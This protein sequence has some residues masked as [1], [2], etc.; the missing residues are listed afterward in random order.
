[1]ETRIITISN[2]KGGTGKTTTA[3]N[4]GSSLALS[5]KKVLLIDFDPQANLSAD[6]DVN[7]EEGEP[8]V[9]DLIMGKANEDIILPTK[10][11]GLHVIPSSI[12]LSS[13]E[14]EL[15][16]E[17]GREM[18]LKTAI[19]R[20]IKN[21][22]FNYIVI[23]TPP[24]L[25]IL[26]INA[27]SV[28]T[29]VIIPVQ[30]QAFAISGIARLIDI[31]N[32]VQSKINPDLLDWMVLPTMVDFRHKEDRLMLEKIQDLYQSNT[33]KTC[34]KVNSKLIVASRKGLAINLYDKNSTG[35]QEYESLAQELLSREMELAIGAVA[36]SIK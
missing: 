24:S 4:L 3:I 6:I 21:K 18:Q 23:D 28:A 2:Q 32:V 25:G 14:A 17:I 31:I 29:N 33:F 35:A 34:I 27:L 13:A 7:V 36:E 12:E 16:A 19:A 8:T 22:T 1:M 9:Y 10:I 26:L 20:L 11:K 15:I 5:G 30:A